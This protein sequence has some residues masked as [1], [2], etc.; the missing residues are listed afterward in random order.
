M[1]RRLHRVAQRRHVR[2]Q[3]EVL[4]HHADLA[5]HAAQVFGIRAHGAALLVLPHGLAVDLDIA[6]GGLVQRHQHAQQGGLAAAGA[7][8][9]R[10]DLVALDGQ[11]RTNS[12]GSTVCGAE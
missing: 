4:E 8:Q 1:H 7:S 6:A 10:E 3:V 2:E 12:S 9:Q 5:A 11:T